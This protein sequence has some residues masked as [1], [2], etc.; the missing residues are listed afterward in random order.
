ME[1]PSTTP[2]SASLEQSVESFVDNLFAKKPKRQR[3]YGVLFESFLGPRA[4]QALNIAE[5]EAERLGQDVIRPEHLL[6]G[7]ASDPTGVGAVV[8]DRLRVTPSHVRELV[9]HRM[10]QHTTRTPQRPLPLHEE[11]RQLLH[12]AL[13]SATRELQHAYAR[14]E[15]LLY[16]LAT[17][18]GKESLVG[19]ILYEDLKLKPGQI[20]RET[21]R[22]LQL[23]R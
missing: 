21:K 16:A 6:Y 23:R 14:T 18:I 8:L 7:I 5:R 12:T 13:T 11:T 2:D 9:E 4:R 17:E 20:E 22:F 3:R 15:H 1:D 19:T 10:Q